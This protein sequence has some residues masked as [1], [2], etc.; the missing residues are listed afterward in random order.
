MSPFARRVSFTRRSIVCRS[1]RR[2]SWSSSSSRRLACPSLSPTF[3]TVNSFSP[4]YLATIAETDASQG[5]F[6]QMSASRCISRCDD[7]NYAVWKIYSNSC[8]VSKCFLICVCVICRVC[9][10]CNSTSCWYFRLINGLSVYYAT[11]IS[12]CISPKNTVV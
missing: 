8:R 2:L 3:I 4:L 9:T 11:K 7:V 12:A 10:R 5:R 1:W 6:S